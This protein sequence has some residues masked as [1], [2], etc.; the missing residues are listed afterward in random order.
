MT[1]AECFLF[2]QVALSCQKDPRAIAF[3]APELFGDA[4]FMRSL[5]ARAKPTSP[6]GAGGWVEV[7]RQGRL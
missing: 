5:Q 3:A 6:G 1:H 7:T 2:L 4:K